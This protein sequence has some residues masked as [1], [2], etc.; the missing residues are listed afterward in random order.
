VTM[1]P[2]HYEQLTDG[3]LC[4]SKNCVAAAGVMAAN[5]ATNG[6]V[7]LNASQ[8][9]SA[10]G[11]SC[12][13]GVDTATGGIPYTALIR[14]LDSLTDGKVKGTLRGLA[15]EQAWSLLV[16]GHPMIVSIGYGPMVGTRCACSAG[17][18]G[19][20]AIYLNAGRGTG[21][22]R[23]VQVGDPLADGRRNYRKGFGWCDFDMIWRCALASPASTGG[24]ICVVFEDT[25][26]VYRTA[27]LRAP[28]RTRPS[29]SAPISKASGKALYTVVGK[30]W[31]TRRTVTGEGKWKGEGHE[32]WG[33][34]EVKT[35][36]GRLG[37]V[38]GPAFE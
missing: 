23:Q 29:R 27:R 17:F 33:W 32:G 6:R 5:R 7:R 37:Y 34:W 26:G 22:D 36:T 14:A 15:K 20:H 38:A 16:A 30:R 21:N 18:A 4:P 24:A 35:R 3:S 28:I 19:G 13:P 25:E 31:W 9:R 11:I 1:T 12:K 10:S 8:I 2:I